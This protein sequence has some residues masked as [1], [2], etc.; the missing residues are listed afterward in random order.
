MRD[1]HIL[2]HFRRVFVVDVPAVPGER[3]VGGGEC[4][5]GFLY[6]SKRVRARGGVVRLPD[7]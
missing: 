1:R 5:A 3:G 4:L 6:L 2:K 7:L